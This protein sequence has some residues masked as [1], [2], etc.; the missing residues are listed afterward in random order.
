MYKKKNF[1]EK[2]VFVKEKPKLIGSTNY[3]LL[4]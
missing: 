2:K 3:P 1:T 4:Y